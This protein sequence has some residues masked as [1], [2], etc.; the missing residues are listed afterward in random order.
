M[1]RH[2]SY[3]CYIRIVP[4]TSRLKKKTIF[5][6]GCFVCFVCLFAIQELRTDLAMQLSQGLRKSLVCKYFTGLAYL[7]PGRLT[8]IDG[9]HRGTNP[10]LTDH[11][12]RATKSLHGELADSSSNKRPIKASTEPQ[13]SHVLPLKVAFLPCSTRGLSQNVHSGRE[14]PQEQSCLFLTQQS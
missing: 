11:S 7:L 1:K 14:N 4:Q 6:K 2:G 12:V 13:E 5:Y 3:S 10:S 9:Q 8:S